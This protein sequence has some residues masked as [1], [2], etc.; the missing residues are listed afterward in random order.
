MGAQ[1]RL[2]AKKRFPVGGRVAAGAGR[3][4]LS[5]AQVAQFVREGHLI[6]PLDDLGVE[7]HLG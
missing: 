3:R 7:V 1:G 4:P 6:M 5:P 2:T